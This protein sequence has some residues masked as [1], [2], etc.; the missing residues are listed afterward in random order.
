MSLTT[1]RAQVANFGANC[2]ARGLANIATRPCECATEGCGKARP[3]I[4][5]E[6][7][8]GNSQGTI[9]SGRGEPMSQREG[10]PQPYWT[11]CDLQLPRSTRRLG[12]NFW[13]EEQISK[14]TG[15]SEPCARLDR[16]LL[17]GAAENVGGPWEDRLL[18]RFFPINSLKKF[19]YPMR[20]GMTRFPREEKRV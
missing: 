8:V 7:K 14:A 6:L 17:K 5:M 16:W 15:F 19:K 13:R 20:N 12:S 3:K 4:F 9:G 18:E 2:G 10:R 1:A 11:G